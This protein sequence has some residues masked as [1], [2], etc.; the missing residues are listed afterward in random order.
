[1]AERPILFSAPMVRHILGGRKKQTRRITLPHNLACGDTLWVRETWQYANW[2]ED[3]IPFIGYRADN[4][5]LLRER[6]ISEEWAERL[7]DIWAGLSEDANYNIDGRAADRRWRP[8]IH[9][10][11]WACRLTLRVTEVRQQWLQDISE[12][13]ARWEGVGMLLADEWPDPMEMTK[14]IQRSRADGFRLLWDSINAGRGYSWASNPQVWV[15]E[16]EPLPSG[17]P[18]PGGNDE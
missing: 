8:A 5:V 9:M 11:R 3:G 13:D 18:V 10:P 1:M 15:I 7:M 16:F 17:N 14:A 4:E 2:T 6:G 12:Y